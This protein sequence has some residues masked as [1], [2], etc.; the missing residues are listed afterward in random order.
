[1]RGM[2]TA[3]SLACGAGLC[4]VAAGVYGYAKLDAWRGYGENFQTGYIVGYLD[5]VALA[6]RHDNR[7]WVPSN[8]KPNFERWRKMVDEFYDDPA[9]ANRPVPDAMAVVGKKLQDEML[10]EYEAA[11]R[12]AAASSPAPSPEP[13][14]S[15]TRRP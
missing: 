8:F 15:P 4:L 13:P 9:N 11:R 12:A 3:A 7:L 14:A 6:K 2:K 5:A 10:A 1:M